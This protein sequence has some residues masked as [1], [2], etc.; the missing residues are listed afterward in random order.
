MLDET[1]TPDAAVDAADTGETADPGADKPKKKAAA[2]KAPAK[3]A[4][5]KKTAAKKT[6][7]KKTAAPAE[8]PDG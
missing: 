3:K 8:E 5:A 2:K 7:A 6:A 4:A 1:P